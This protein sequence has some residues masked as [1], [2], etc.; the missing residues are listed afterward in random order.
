MATLTAEQQARTD[1]INKEVIDNAKRKN[2]G[3]EK[4]AKSKFQ[5]VMWSGDNQMA[6]TP[7]EVWQWLH[8][9]FGKKLFD[10]CPVNPQYDGREIP[11]EKNNYINPPYNECG[12]WLKK[13]VEETRK[14]NRCIALIPNRTNNNWYHDYVIPFAE[15]IYLVKN[16][17]KFKGYKK[18]APFPI[19]I[20]VYNPETINKGNKPTIEGINF[21][22]KPVKE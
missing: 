2:P 15:H 1:K 9:K 8:E 5:R 4:W 14:G 7:D 3:L 12:I 6:Q 16:G 11:W 20:V 17:V 13:C 22:P 19:C 21:Y 18:K 10:P